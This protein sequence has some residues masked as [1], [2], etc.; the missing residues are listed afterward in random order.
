MANG[1]FALATMRFLTHGASMTSD[2]QHRR[3][4]LFSVRLWVEPMRDGETEIRGRVHH[5][6]SG[7]VRYFRTMSAL[8]T[9]MLAK[10][11]DIES[12]NSDQKGAEDA[13]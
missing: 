13:A 3:S 7:D 4:H 5:V 10:V 12:G 2:Q 1:V 6:L 9:F 11:Q 8:S